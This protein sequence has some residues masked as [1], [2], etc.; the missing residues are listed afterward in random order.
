MGDFIVNN[1]SLSCRDLKING[2][3][4]PNNYSNVNNY[5]LRFNDPETAGIGDPSGISWQPASTVILNDNS[6]SINNNYYMVMNPGVGSTGSTLIPKTNNYLRSGLGS[7]TG[8]VD[9]KGTGLSYT[10][11]GQITI[12]LTAEDTT[13]VSNVFGSSMT[14]HLS[15]S[16]KDVSIIS[17]KENTILPRKGGLDYNISNKSTK[18]DS[19]GLKRKDN[20]IWIKYNNF[21]EELHNKH[22][23]GGK[24]DGNTLFPYDNTNTSIG[25]NSG[26]ENRIRWGNEVS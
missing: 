12:G 8:G 11:K 10:P 26:N 13:L 21:N 9:N 15:L 24:T 18:I 25:A 20:G 23:I 17:K 6:S 7:Q 16:H 22:I 2:Q 3:L 19:T 1:S 5:Y 14:E 4:W